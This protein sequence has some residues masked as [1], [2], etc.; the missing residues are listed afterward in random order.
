MAADESNPLRTDWKRPNR[1]KVWMLAVAFGLLGWVLHDALVANAAH[2]GPSR[3]FFLAAGF[4]AATATALFYQ[5]EQAEP[6]GGDQ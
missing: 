3:V 4:G 6:D 2:V 1:E 5:L